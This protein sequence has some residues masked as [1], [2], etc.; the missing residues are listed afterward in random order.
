FLRRGSAGERAGSRQT[1]VLPPFAYAVIIYS[2]HRD[3][4]IIA[5]LREQRC[6][7]CN[8]GV[9][10]FESAV[11]ATFNERGKWL[12]RCSNRHCD[13]TLRDDELLTQIIYK[14]KKFVLPQGVQHPE[15]TP[16]SD[17]WLGE[18]LKHYKTG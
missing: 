15:G 8:N 11:P 10:R 12:H 13:E 9:F 2:M 1:P 18:T 14:G 3:D 4:L 6:T 7:A 5:T 16:R 17:I